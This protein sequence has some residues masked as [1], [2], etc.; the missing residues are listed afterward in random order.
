MDSSIFGT[1]RTVALGFIAVGRMFQ[2]YTSPC[3]P[4]R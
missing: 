4:D 3:K 1:A 2:N